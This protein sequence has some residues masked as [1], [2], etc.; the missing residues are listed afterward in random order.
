MKLHDS[1]VYDAVR[2]IIQ[3]S[4]STAEE[5]IVIRQVERALQDEKREKVKRRV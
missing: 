4:F 3:Q 1:T 2:R 5:T